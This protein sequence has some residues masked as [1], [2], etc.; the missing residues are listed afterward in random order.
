MTASG[1]GRCRRTT[2]PSRWTAN[3]SS[4]YP[5]TL[6]SWSMPESLH[7]S[8]VWRTAGLARRTSLRRHIDHLKR[9]DRPTNG[10]LDRNQGLL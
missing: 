9:H 3:W 6:N 4:L 7:P 2:V 8:V 5:V 10:T 1:L